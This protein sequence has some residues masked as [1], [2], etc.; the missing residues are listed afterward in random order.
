MLPAGAG[1]LADDRLSIGGEKEGL[2]KLP[3][4]GAYEDN[5]EMVQQ[6]VKEDPKLVA[7]VVRNWIAEDK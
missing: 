6:V 4:H 5:I 7:Q 3:G 1:G 2:I